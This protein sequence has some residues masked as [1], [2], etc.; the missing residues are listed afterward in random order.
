MKELDLRVKEN[1]GMDCLAIRAFETL[2]RNSF[3]KVEQLKDFKEYFRVLMS[4]MVML[5][6]MQMNSKSSLGRTG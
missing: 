2:I 6:N 1:R 5:L 4:Y 3:M